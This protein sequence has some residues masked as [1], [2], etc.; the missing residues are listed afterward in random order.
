MRLLWL[1][2]FL[3]LAELTFGQNSYLTRVSGGSLLPHRESVRP[4]ITDHL[5]G[6]EFQW[7][8]KV[9]GKEVW[10]QL[11][12]LPELG[13][14]LNYANLGN[15]GILGEQWSLTPFIFL[16]LGNNER[17][18]RQHLQFGLGVGYTNTVWS[19]ES[20]VKST[21]LSSHFNASILLEYGLEGDLNARREDRKQRLFW[22]AGCRIHHF[23]NAAW[24]MPNLG[25]NN[26][27]LFVGL[28][29]QFKPETA[30]AK[31][32]NFESLDFRPWSFLI[33]YGLGFRENNPPLGV[34]HAI[35]T[36]RL[37]G[38]KRLTPKSSIGLSPEILF[39][40]SLAPLLSI[41]GSSP[42]TSELLQAGLALQYT[43]HFDQVS[44]HA[45]MGTYVHNK[46]DFRG[47]LYS[48]IGL[49]YQFGKHFSTHL[50]LKTHAFKADHAEVGI[51]YQ[52]GT[53]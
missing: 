49:R 2:F 26:L 50:M 3:S 1:F 39:N 22:S 16:P 8:K 32:M 13:V 38:T 45:M 34:R 5:V 24:K 28:G 20:N 33:S 37:E 15:K 14:L 12:A 42:S 51:A 47:G 18:T 4:L 11:Y 48:R 19:L 23:S 7:R 35:H 29:M 46:S 40:R 6:A 27:L 25:T 21:V 52:L 53:N 36:L 17:R 31:T 44:F 30:A 10:H 9:S 43:M 41:E